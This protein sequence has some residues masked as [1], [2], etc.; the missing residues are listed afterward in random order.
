MR[1]AGLRHIR[2]RLA[3]WS[4]LVFG[5][6]L[7]LYASGTSWF[8]LKTL[9]DQL[10][11]SLKEDLELVDQML[12]HS[13]E[14]GAPIDIHGEN[15][16]E[17]E[18]F[19]EIWS[20][21]GQLIYRSK[22]LGAHALGPAP[23]TTGV[24]TTT[25]IHSHTLSDGTQLRVAEKLHFHG[26]A[27]RLIR[28]GV[29]EEGHFSNVNRFVRLILIGIPVALLLVSVSAY[30]MARGALR[31]IDVMASAARR[32]G[33]SDLSERIPV[34]NPD[35]ELG[36][37]ASAFNELLARIQKS[38]DQLKRF[39]SDAS[40]QLR[41]PLTAMRSVGEVGLQVGRSAEE[42][43]EVVGSML[44][45][46]TRLTKLVDSLLF[47]TRADAGKHR[48]NVDRLDLLEYVR[49]TTDLL[50]VLADDKHQ[51][52]RV[53]GKPGI[54]IRADRSLLCQALLNLVDNAIKFTPEGGSI[55]IR[56]GVNGAQQAFVDVVD[57]GPGISPEHLESIFERFFRA[58][59]SN[60]P[61]AGLGLAVARWAVEAHG[62]TI[63]V[64]S[65]QG[66]GSAFHVV[67]PLDPRLT[68]P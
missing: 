47:L 37:L 23:D 24:G 25:R 2:F 62:G 51:Q 50:G 64:E 52:M 49:E 44:E 17:L 66:S 11:A 33:T 43:R 53:D 6:I 14:G 10:D 16:N 45:E 15:I 19:L 30:W 8:F 27:H 34:R 4:I 5:G 56:V 35:D 67:L 39:T 20:M 1:L 42:Y 63:T 21:D 65:N 68:K 12:V 3:L 46:S 40:H 7:V 54:M 31:P 29:S 36:R 18:R 9:N 58:D 55:A 57:S 41:T 61:G 28:L 26:A 22:T 59:K 60:S 13:V 48:L 32:M 38:Y